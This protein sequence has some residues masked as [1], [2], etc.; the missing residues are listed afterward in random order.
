MDT[1]FE[2]K[3]F[4]VSDF[5]NSRENMLIR[6]KRLGDYELHWHDCFEI[7]LILH[8]SASQCLN[9]T[10]YSLTEGDIYLL[11][12]TDFH[13]VKG[14]GAEVYNIMFSESLMS[15]DLLQKILN[16]DQNILF[17]LND[18]EFRDVASIIARMLG[19]FEHG[20]EYSSVYIENLLECLFILFL[21]KCSISVKSDTHIEN[22]EIQKSL[23]FLHGHFRENPS[24]SAAAAMSGF[25][26]N[27]FSGLFHEKT[28]KTYKEY[29][30]A[31]KLEYSKKLLLSGDLSITEICYASGFNSLTNFLRAF[32]KKYGIAPGAM[33]KVHTESGE[34]PELPEG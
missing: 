4:L 28:G 7:E 6:R 10:E 2:Y 21:R 3:R 19:E 14:N 5:E 26:R 31:L 12:P 27:Y 1:S 17:H 15:D 8:G 22:S 23:L 33:R 24:M 13:S 34:I 30:N 9:G 16:V 11:N 20:D 25:N 32:K 18:G 29:L